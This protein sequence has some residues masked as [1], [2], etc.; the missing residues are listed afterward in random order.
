MDDGAGGETGGSLGGVIGDEEGGGGAASLIGI[1]DD[2]DPGLYQGKSGFL[3]RS[4]RKLY[5]NLSNITKRKAASSRQRQTLDPLLD[6]ATSVK[7]AH[8]AH[9]AVDHRELHPNKS[10]LPRV[11]KN[12]VNI[13][14]LISG[15]Q[16]VS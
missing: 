10:N 13:E 11:A 4:W 3:A 7:G 9:T 6:E 2:D 12:Q 1:C 16:D 14:S 15:I 5:W 8:Q